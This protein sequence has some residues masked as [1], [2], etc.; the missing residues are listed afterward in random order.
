[1]NKN[2]IKSKISVVIIGILVALYAIFYGCICLVL[3]KDLDNPFMLLY[4]LIPVAMLIGIIAVVKMRFTEIAKGEI[5]DAR[6][7]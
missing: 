5:D 1:M 4:G 7:Y 6:K 2:K 3:Y